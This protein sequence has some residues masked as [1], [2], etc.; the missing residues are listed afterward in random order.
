MIVNSESFPGVVATLQQH[1]GLIAFDIETTGLNAYRDRI[2]GIALAIP[3]PDGS[4]Q[5]FYFPTMHG[6]GENLS[7]AL[8]RGM[9]NELVALPQLTW[10]TWNGKFDFTYMVASGLPVPANVL[11]VQLAAHLVEE[12]AWSFGLKQQGAALL[13]VES[14]DPQKELISHLKAKG[15]GKGDMWQLPAEL[16]APYAEQDVKLTYQLAQMYSK[17]LR[18]WQLLPL[19]RE[20][21]QYMLTVMRMEMNGLR[22]DDSVLDDRI[23][24]AQ[25]QM[26]QSRAR[27]S[28][29]FGFDINPN[30]P[31]QVLAALRVYD[32]KLESTDHDHLT[33]ML[34]RYPIVDQILLYREWSKVAGAYYVPFRKFS[35][36]GIL[37]PNFNMTGTVT[38]R[39][40]CSD[41]NLQAI[42]RKA[43]DEHG[44][45]PRSYVKT[46]FIAREG[47]TLLQADYKQAEVFLGAHY[48][49]ARAL[50]Q[51]LESGVDIH[52]ATANQ[53]GIPRSAAKRLNFSMQYGIGEESLAD[54]LGVSIR[55]AAMYLEKYN[56]LH[57]EM[58]QLYSR[59]DYE[60]RTHG[61]IRLFTGRKR[62]YNSWDEAQKRGVKFS[63]THKASSNLVQGTVG[64]VMRLS[65]TALEK[66]LGAEVKQLLHVHDSVLFEVPDNR[67]REVVPEINR[68]MTEHTKVFD[69]PLQVDIEAGKRWFNLTPINEYMK[70]SEHVN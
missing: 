50:R 52:L 8:V 45:R 32:P 10:L 63:P 21:S 5:S 29:S 15:L 7:P 3:L 23:A 22:L 70:D 51:M 67:V 20:V 62:S 2:C 40:S 61:Y 65:S 35:V 53:L 47:H 28:E 60:G 4:E 48:A 24:E 54:D 38:A 9:M 34:A 56:S 49:K 64:E 59:M 1:E 43:E 41:P 31:K 39:F 13:G 57:P 55:E 66:E 6:E 68:L 18:Y 26:T 42:P 33:A 14:G 19:W 46:A 11:D 27:L 36:D 44:L 30:S 37:H 16:V 17:H 69:I 25:E 58:R 12:N